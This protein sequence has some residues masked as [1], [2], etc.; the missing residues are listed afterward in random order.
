[1]LP[2]GQMS[3]WGG[4]LT[5][6]LLCFNAVSV[7]KPD[8]KF[9]SMFMGLIDGDGYI[10]IGPQKQYNKSSNV[11]KSTIRARLVI[12]LHTRDKDLLVY[13]TKVLGV[14]SISGLD[15]K[16]QTRLIFSK[17][18][19]FTVIIPLIK[20]YNLEFL[21]YNRAKQYALLS[22]IID[23][24]IVHW[25]NVNFSPV[26]LEHSVEYLLKLDFFAG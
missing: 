6:S 1:V 8:K 16:N 12:R 22:Y 9:L 14:G 4:D 20:M 24:Q 18:D 25:E 5:N 17:K 11:P 19:L 10:E 2:Y 23:N 7:L 21:T 13:L 15:S 26:M 3:L